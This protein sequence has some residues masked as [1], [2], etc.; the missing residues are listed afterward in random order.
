MDQSIKNEWGELASGNDHGVLWTIIIS[1]IKPSEVLSD[2]VPYLSFV[3]DH[4]SLRTKNI[5]GD[6]NSSR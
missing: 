3:C 6:K 4:R 5:T 2:K 1:F